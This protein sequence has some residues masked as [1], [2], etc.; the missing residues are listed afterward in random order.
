MK[1]WII[2]AATVL[3]FAFGGIL[4]YNNYNEG[5]VGYELT[6]SFEINNSE[7]KDCCSYKDD[8]ETKICRILTRYDCSLCDN[9]CNS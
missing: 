6:E 9:R 3:L 8:G 5:V 4:L 2:I 7:L 1:T